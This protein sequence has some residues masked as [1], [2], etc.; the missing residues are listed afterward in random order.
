MEE[1]PFYESGGER[2][3]KRAVAGITSYGE[4]PYGDSDYRPFKARRSLI[5]LQ[6]KS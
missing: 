4:K 6:N 2:D 5:G 3:G 1:A